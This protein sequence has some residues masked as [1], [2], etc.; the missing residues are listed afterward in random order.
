MKELT[1]REEQFCTLYALLQNETEAAR[2]AGFKLTPKKSGVRMLEREEIRKRISEKKA[3]FE[4]T[5]TAKAGLRRLAFGSIADAVKLMQNSILDPDELD[6][7]MVSDLKIGASGITEIKFF[8]RHKALESLACL[9]GAANDSDGALPF[10]KALEN[11][12][13]IVSE[14]REENE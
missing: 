14:K 9:E 7:F 10:Y 3:E 4:D 5:A 12:A 2:L 13:K 6:L 1:K 8:D 11:S